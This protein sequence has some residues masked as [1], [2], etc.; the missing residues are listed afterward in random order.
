MNFQKR[1]FSSIFFLY[2][3]KGFDAAQ[4]SHNIQQFHKI[5]AMGYQENHRL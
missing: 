2:F 5:M 4:Q 3:K 1:N